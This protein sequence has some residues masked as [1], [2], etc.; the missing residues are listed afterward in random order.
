MPRYLALVLFGLGVA[1]CSRSTAESDAGAGTDRDN[2]A[3]N[4]RDRADNAVTP[5]DQKENESDLKL[6]QEI[7]QA[8]VADDGLSFDG[9]NVK[10]ITQDGKVF[11][12][13][14]VASAQ[15]RASIEAAAKRVAGADNVTNEIEIKQ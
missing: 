14:P 11:L 6:T 7:R 1:A 10:I 4:S 9:K 2:T 12:R 3:V 5:P 13:G 8:V 15:E